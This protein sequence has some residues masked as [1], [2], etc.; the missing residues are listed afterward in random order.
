M[1]DLWF[2]HGQ[3][4]DGGAMCLQALNCDERGSTRI[5]FREKGL[6][7]RRHL[8]SAWRGAVDVAFPPRLAKASHLERCLPGRLR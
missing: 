6:R 4:V 1:G 3:M 8:L 2:D 5:E 7:G